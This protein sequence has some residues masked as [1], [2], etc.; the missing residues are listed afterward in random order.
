MGKKK[1]RRERRRG[2]RNNEAKRFERRAV[3]C[4]ITESA[5]SLAE[6][7]DIIS[8]TF[9]A[10]GTYWFRGHADIAW[11]LAPG[12]LRHQQEGTRTRALD[13][14]A[15]FRRYAESKLR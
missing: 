14:L 4:G 2:Q 1:A 3:R 13:L 10:N 5:H 7:L 6:F 11:T 8:S 12:A 15:D 9:G